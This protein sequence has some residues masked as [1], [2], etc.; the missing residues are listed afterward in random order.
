LL[1]ANRLEFS[2]FY[3]LFVI[4][5]IACLIALMIYFITLLLKFCK[6]AQDNETESS[7]PESVCLKTPR[8]NL[9]AFLS[10][11]DNK[12]DSVGGTSRK[13]QADKNSTNGLDTEK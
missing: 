6:R 7:S 12:D 10:F 5:G 2:S 8:H 4:C 9:Q 13:S 11:V 3:G 1:E